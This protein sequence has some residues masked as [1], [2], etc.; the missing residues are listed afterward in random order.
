MLPIRSP[1]PIKLESNWDPY[2]R[3]VCLRGEHKHV[4]LFSDNSTCGPLVE[5]LFAWQVQ[6]HLKGFL[7]DLRTLLHSQQLTGSTK[8]CCSL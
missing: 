6:R 2:A 5:A 4:P 8:R 7:D 1:A 3:G